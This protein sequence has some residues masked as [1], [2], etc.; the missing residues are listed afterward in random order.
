[1]PRAYHL[2]FGAY[3]FWLPNDPRGSWST[4]VG[5]WD[6]Y[7]YGPATK[8]TETRSLAARQHDHQRRLAAK[9]AL[10]RPAVRFGG[11]QIRSIAN[12]FARYATRTQLAVFAC[13]IMPNHVHLVVGTRRLEP[14]Q[15]VIQ[16]KAAATRQLLHDGLHPYKHLSPGGRPPKCF[17]RGQWKV[18]LD[19]DEQIARAI[20]YTENNPP[21]EELPAQHWQFITPF[22]SQLAVS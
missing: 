17:A 4:F 16:L 21:K 5:S 13:A 14:H 22:Q 12:G 18:F 15:L 10:K 20:K 7:R 9:R 3:G 6:L 11:D 19:T 8:T 1:M 2:I